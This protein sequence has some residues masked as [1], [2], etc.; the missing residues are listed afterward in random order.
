[1]KKTILTLCCIGNV[2]SIVMSPY[3]CIG[4][5]TIY[6]WNSLDTFYITTI[7]GTVVSAVVNVMF[8]MITL[9]ILYKGRTKGKIDND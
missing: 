8:L 1:M 6:F 2:L 7:I 3:F 5:T 4:F 9:Y